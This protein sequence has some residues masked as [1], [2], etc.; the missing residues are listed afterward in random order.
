MA[1]IYLCAKRCSKRVCIKN[2]CDDETFGQAITERYCSP[3]NTDSKTY[4]ADLNY[5]VDRVKTKFKNINHLQHVVE[6]LQGTPIAAFE[7]N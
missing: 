5:S 6:E 3:R 1:F 4:K 7:F 2:I